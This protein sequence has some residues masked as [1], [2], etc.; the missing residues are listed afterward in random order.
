MRDN[1]V[2]LYPDRPPLGQ[3]IR[4][5]TTGHVQLETLLESGR[6]PIERAVVDGAMVVA[7]ASLI[8]ALR[9]CGRELVLETGV[10][11]LSSLGRYESV[12]RKSAWA[13]AGRPLTLADFEG[14]GG[15][16]RLFKIASCAVDNGF[17]TVLSPSHV[18]SNASDPAFGVDRRCCERLRE[19]LDSIGGSGIAIDYELLITNHVLRDD[20]QRAILIGGLC[21]LPFDNLWVRTSGFGAE[22]TPIGVRRYVAA[23][24]DFIALGRPIVADGVAG[25]AGLA[26]LAFGAAGA[27]GHGVGVL[28]RFDAASWNRAPKARKGGGQA[29]RALVPA[30]DRQLTLKQFNAVTAAS[31]GRALIS[32]N[33]RRCC[34]RGLDD[35][36]NDPKGHYLWRRKTQLDAL[37]RVPEARRA[38][39]F[40]SQDLAQAERYARML[41]R[42]KIND[43][44]TQ[45]LISRES[46]R[47]FKLH[48]VLENFHMHENTGERALTPPVRRSANS[49]FAQGSR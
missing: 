48:Q 43:L 46:D 28:E 29:I 34:K 49:R 42:L 23:L 12:V 2:E 21:G 41:S 36:F 4:V 18:L 24:R 20:A 10:A 17:H 7:Q 11:E 13:V 37:S 9:E 31:G 22:A 3:Y 47:L 45:Q 15:D 26:A 19:I 1:V 6:L 40:I 35:T 14:S 5:G 33:D 25:L 27:L 16:E 32:C 30:L 39:H 38:E 44:E 8:K